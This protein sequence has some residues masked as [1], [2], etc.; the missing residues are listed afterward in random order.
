MSVRQGLVIRAASRIGITAVTVGIGIA[1]TV[2]ATVCAVIFVT[3]PDIIAALT[4][5]AA[6]GRVNIRQGNIC[7]WIFRGWKIKYLKCNFRK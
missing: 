7:V 2:F 6:V 3:V 5:R 1:I 4:V